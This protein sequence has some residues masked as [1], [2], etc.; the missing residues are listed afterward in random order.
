MILPDEPPRSARSRQLATPFI[1]GSERGRADPRDLPPGHPGRRAAEEKLAE[2]QE[3]GEEDN[4][5]E[6]GIPE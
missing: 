6:D 1:S 2:A 3:R 4:Q 5:R